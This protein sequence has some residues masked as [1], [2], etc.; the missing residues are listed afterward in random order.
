MRIVVALWWVLA[1]AF[2][3][4]F[5]QAIAP[6]HAGDMAQIRAGFQGRPLLL[7][8]WSLT[9][10][11]CLEE[12]PQW[13]QRIRQNP[14]VAFVFINTDG[15]AQSAAAAR[16]LAIAGVKPLRSLIYAD[17]FVERLQFEIAPDWRGELPRT[18]WSAAAG[19]NLVVLGSVSDTMFRQW[20]A[21]AKH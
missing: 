20:M 17:D 19:P 12:M 14:G 10:A 13:T 5:A 3:S 4:V 8:V 21:Q 6:L 9:C 15:V 7:H 2:T 1:S 16:R 11:P 18:E